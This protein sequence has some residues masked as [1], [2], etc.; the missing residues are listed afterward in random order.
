MRK[1]AKSHSILIL[2]LLFYGTTRLVNLTVLPIF[3]DESI[4]IY[5]AKIIES[6]HSQWFISLTDGKPPLLVWMTA[7]FLT[8]LPDGWYL[9][10]GRLSAVIAG[11]VSVVAIF[12]LTELLFEDVKVAIVTTLLYIIFPFAL[13]YDRMALFDPLLQ[14]T[15]L[16]SAYF[17]IKTAKTLSV[18]YA[19]LWGFSL[20]LAFLSKP[21]AILFMGLLPLGYLMFSF[22]K[23]KKHWKKVV[24]L[25]LLAVVVAE[26][27]NN[28]QRVSSV[29]FMAGIKNAQFQ[30]PVEELLRNP[31]ALTIGNMQGFISWI[32]GYYTLP[33]LLIGLI[34]FIALVYRHFRIGVLL[35]ALW[36]VPIIALATV[37]REI[38]PRY[39]LFTVP[40]FLI[41]LG[42]IIFQAFTYAGKKFWVV[43]I[44]VLVLIFPLLRMD[45]YLLTS[46][47][48]ASLP[49]TDYDQLVGTHPSGYG[50]D[51]AYNFIND[52]IS[53]G[54][55]VTLV[56]QGTF[57]LY[58][59][60]FQLEYWDDP[61][62]TILPKWP[63]DSI[64]DEI[65]AAQESSRVIIILK[66]HSEIPEKLPLNLIKKIEKPSGEYPLLL[67]ELQQ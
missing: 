63:L 15:L 10:A 48:K 59:Y 66:E 39:M 1:F 56:T 2:L 40:Y 52:Q 36:I 64:D 49:Q 25:G 17:A 55:H 16:S 67:T 14:A 54:Q 9:I 27:I 32:H 19:L 26:I 44:A 47:E 57:G 31:F 18:K 58:P 61:R 34:G 22:E 33:I 24:G 13:L 5:W 21:T 20:G 51:Q 42:Y 6:T 38:F 37:G 45:Y 8:V 46:P 28:L 41:A 65:L 50:L 7:F 23:I 12:K 35:V 53:Q 11:A 3:T 30:Q 60:A 43:G 62:I 4:Y 29:Y